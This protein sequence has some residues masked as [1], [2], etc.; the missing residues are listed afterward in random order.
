MG[1]VRYELGRGDIVPT[2]EEYEDF[3]MGEEDDDY[4]VGDEI[5]DLLEVG[6]A[7]VRRAAAPRRAAAA[8]ARRG[9]RARRRAPR[10]PAARAV[11]RAVETAVAKRIASTKPVIRESMPTQDFEWPLGFDSGVQIAAGA[12][13]IITVTPQ[14]LFRGG[15]LS[16]PGS[17]ASS[18]TI[19]DVKVGQ[20]S[21]F[22]AVSSVPA[23]TFS[24]LSPGVRLKLSTSQIGQQ[25]SMDVT[26]IG[27]APE[28]FRATII[29]QVAD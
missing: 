19:N 18:F 16:V 17:I 22:P 3:E 7:V 24:N 6:Q 15:R 21:M 20:R 13:A 5:E 14:T 4:Y 8:P 10:A 1:A 26:N 11:A 9:R 2:E 12:T 28:R 23:E 29:G 27:L 25:V